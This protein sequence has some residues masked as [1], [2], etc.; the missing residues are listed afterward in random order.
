MVALN[1]MT[2]GARRHR[3]RRRAF[4]TTVL[5]G[6]SKCYPSG[7]EVVI[8]VARRQGGDRKAGATYGL[9]QRIANDQRPRGAAGG[10]ADIDP[11][12][13]DAPGAAGPPVDQ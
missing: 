9:R 6:P 4:T 3:R 5:L 7:G 12:M 11:V 2:S 10:H 1:E 13:N 8:R